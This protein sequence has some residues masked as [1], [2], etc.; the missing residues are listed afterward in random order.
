MLNAASMFLI[1][2]HLHIFRGL[3][4]GS[5]SSP[6]EFVRCIGVVIFLLM[7]SNYE[8]LDPVQATRK[9]RRQARKEPQST[10]TPC[11]KIPEFMNL[12]SLFLKV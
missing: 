2:V 7:I 3:Y 9:V 8:W 5:Y 6:R 10:T 12:G 11:S 1:V 4:H